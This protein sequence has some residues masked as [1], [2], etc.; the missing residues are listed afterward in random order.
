MSF[1]LEKYRD[2]PSPVHSYL[3]IAFTTVRVCNMD[4]QAVVDSA[5]I[6]ILKGRLLYYYNSRHLP[7]PFPGQPRLR[8]CYC[9]LLRLAQ[10]WISW[11]ENRL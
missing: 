3:N 10:A 9:C 1:L 8:L 2:Q 6:S 7:S 11:Q 4:S 5:Y